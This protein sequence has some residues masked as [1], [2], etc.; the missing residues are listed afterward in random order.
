MSRG[1]VLDIPAIMMRLPHRYPFLLVDR[2]TECVPGDRI[3]AVKNVSINEPFFQG[4]FP[5]RPLMPGVL[6]VE[7]MAQATGILTYETVGG[8]GQ[9]DIIYYFVGIDKAR[10]KRPVE[11]GDQLILRAQLLKSRHQVW[12]F[13]TTAQVDGELCAEAEL[14]CAAR[15][16]GARGQTRRGT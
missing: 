3:C 6:I 14:M 12:R 5:G 11:P 8:S 9:E 4:H 15:P 7:A 10:F 1:E 13:S 2:V 16:Y